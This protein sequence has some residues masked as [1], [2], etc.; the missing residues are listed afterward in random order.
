MK[1]VARI[2]AAP[3]R[4]I[5]YLSCNPTT[6]A[7]H[8]ALFVEFDFWPRAVWYNATTPAKHIGTAC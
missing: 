8:C 1:V 5:V 3:S 6:M 2:A 4:G 7:P